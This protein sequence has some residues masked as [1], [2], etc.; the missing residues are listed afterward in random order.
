MAI[1]VINPEEIMDMV[2]NLAIA[3]IVDVI[4]EHMLLMMAMLAGHLTKTEVKFLNPNMPE[5]LQTKL[6][7]AIEYWA[8]NRRCEIEEALAKK[9]G[10]K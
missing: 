8:K 2:E 10:K 9:E 1:H 5:R 3:G 7:Q 4:P 6:A